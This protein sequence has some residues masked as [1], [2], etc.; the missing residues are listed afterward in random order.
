MHL[1]ALQSASWNETVSARGRKRMTEKR[2]IK[3]NIIRLDL[4]TNCL[5][6]GD[7][8]TE[9]DKQKDDT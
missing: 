2:T 7:T 3:L 5:P 6:V 1:K 9:I 4:C 8:H